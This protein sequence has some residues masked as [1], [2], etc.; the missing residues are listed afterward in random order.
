M[1]GSCGCSRN[2][3]VNV[4]NVQLGRRVRESWDV[5]LVELEKA[6]M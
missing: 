6:A 5:E 3:V 2:K 1:D 4:C